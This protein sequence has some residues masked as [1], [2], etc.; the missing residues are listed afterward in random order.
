MCLTKEQKPPM[1]IVAFVD[2]LWARVVA[3]LLWPLHMLAKRLIYKKIHS[4]IGI[5][6]VVHEF[7]F[8]IWFVRFIIIVMTDDFGFHRL[9]LA[10][11]VVYPFMLTSFLR[12][13][14][15][16]FS[17]KNRTISFLALKVSISKDLVLKSCRPSV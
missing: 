11:V 7:Y 14:R 15:H 5:S 13:S 9:V 6:K 17:W 1:Y 4:S 16:N 3:A 12:L 2:W 10:E 8:L